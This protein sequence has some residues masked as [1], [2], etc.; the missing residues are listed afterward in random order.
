MWKK[1]VWYHLFHSF[2]YYLIIL[3]LEKNKIVML[4][5][6]KDESILTQVLT[7]KELTMFD[8][9]YGDVSDTNFIQVIAF[10]CWL[11]WLKV[12][13]EK[14]VESTQPTNIIHMGILRFHFLIL[15]FL[16]YYFE[17]SCTP[18]THVQSKSSTRS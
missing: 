12:V 8:K 10:C 5:V 3:Y 14:V 2:S 18:D 6:K 9:Q 16:Y 7:P 11:I 1:E 15:H 17:I 4:D 13:V